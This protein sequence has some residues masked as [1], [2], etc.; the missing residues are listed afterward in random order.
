[1]PYVI[2]VS[3]TVGVVVVSRVSITIA[4]VKKGM[5]FFEEPGVQN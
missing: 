4:G 2:S 3:P 1:M 5:V